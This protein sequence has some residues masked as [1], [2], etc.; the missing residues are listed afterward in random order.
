MKLPETKDENNSLY[1][2]KA[3]NMQGQVDEETVTQKD[4]VT[5]PRPSNW[6]HWY[7]KPGQKDSRTY[8]KSCYVPPVD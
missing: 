1:L 5:C 8:C 4:E 6:N 7:L 3:H 2:L